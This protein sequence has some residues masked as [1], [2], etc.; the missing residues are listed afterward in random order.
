MA[1]ASENHGRELA[2]GSGRYLPVP[3]WDGN[4]L[5][6]VYCCKLLACSLTLTCPHLGFELARLAEFL[7]WLNECL[8]LPPPGEEQCRQ[9]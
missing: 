9:M 4:L 7:R 2:G 1:G 6:R 3:E 8:F 5:P